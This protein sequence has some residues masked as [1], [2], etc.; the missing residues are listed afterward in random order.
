M[1]GLHHVR[2]Y[3]FLP[4]AT[5]CSPPPP[6]SSKSI[7]S[8]GSA[9]FSSHAHCQSR[10]Q[11]VSAINLPKPGDVSSTKDS[12]EHLCPLRHG[13]T[14]ASWIRTFEVMKLTCPKDTGSSMQAYDNSIR[15]R[16]RVAHVQKAWSSSL[17]TKLTEK[18]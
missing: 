2:R 10:A 13:G 15:S 16:K 12:N 5:V 4:L 11:G 9:I 17:N 18:Q 6:S 1:E 3:L 7:P 14:I 8:S